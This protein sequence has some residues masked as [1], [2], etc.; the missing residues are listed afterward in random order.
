[1]ADQGSGAQKGPMYSQPS[2]YTG[3][4][5]AINS[6]VSFFSRDH[7]PSPLSQI[8][9]PQTPQVPAAAPPSVDDQDPMLSKLKALYR[10]HWGLASQCH[11]AILAYQTGQ[12][13]PSQDLLDRAER[14]LLLPQQPPAPQ[15]S[16]YPQQSQQASALPRT[17]SAPP[18]PQQQQGGE[19]T[20]GLAT[21]TEG[22]QRQHLHNP[23]EHTTT[24]A[25][26]SATMTSQQYH[27]TRG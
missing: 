14:V 18:F 3:C 22:L 9:G 24:S 12:Q 20:A 2:T 16:Q 10:L 11:A 13:Q 15:Y 19:E 17:S 26:M 27:S 7:P 23:F 1:M 6:I 8:D 25:S 21:I 5:F 4:E